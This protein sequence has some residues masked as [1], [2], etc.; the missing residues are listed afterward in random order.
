[1][2][3]NISAFGLVVNM[4]CTSTFPSGIQLTQFADDADPFDM[5]AAI[6]AE[7]GM[8]INGDLLV[9]NKPVKLDISISVVPGGADDENLSILA[10]ANRTGKGLANARDV[11][12]M[13]AMY[14][15]GRTTT[16]SEGFITGAIL[17]NAAQTAGRMKTKTYTFTFE[18]KSG[19]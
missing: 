11:I 3:T 5:P 7:S 18:K 13:T 17:I 6:L 9:W 19:Y 15:D 16:L 8:G 14:P 2:S 10:T 4:V 12:T 1:M